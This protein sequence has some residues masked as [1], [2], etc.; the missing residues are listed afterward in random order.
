M[1]SMSNMGWILYYLWHYSLENTLYNNDESPG[2]KENECVD[3]ARQ[4]PNF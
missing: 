2:R 3:T 4:K 1:L